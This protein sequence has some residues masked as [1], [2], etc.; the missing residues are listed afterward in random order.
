LR[1]ERVRIPANGRLFG[2]EMAVAS[3]QRLLL[4][5]LPSLLDGWFRFEASGRVQGARPA[6]LRQQA[7]SAPDPIMSA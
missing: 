4:L 7:Q 2:F 3:I 6:K 1:I 5:L